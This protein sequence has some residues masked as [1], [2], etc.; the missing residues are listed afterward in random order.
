MSRGTVAQGQSMLEEAAVLGSAFRRE[1]TRQAF[2]A[3][4]PGQENDSLPTVQKKPDVCYHGHWSG[5]S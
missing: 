1:G 3:W 4:R 5:E 2:R